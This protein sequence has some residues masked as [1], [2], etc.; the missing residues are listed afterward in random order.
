MKEN[1][2]G[3]ETEVNAYSIENKYF[4]IEKKEL[5]LENDRLLEERMYCDIMCT[6]L[7]YVKDMDLYSELSC[8]FINKCVECE[9]LESELSKQIEKVKNKSFNELL[10]L[11]AKLEEFSISLELSLKHYKE[12]IICNESL[13]NHDASLISDINNKSF[14]INDL[15]SQLQDKSIAVDELKKLLNKLN[16]K[17]KV[18]QCEIQPLDSMSQKLED[19]NVSLKFQ[20]LSL[21]KENEHL[22]LVYKNLYDSIKQTQAQTKLKTNSLQEK[23]NA[24]ISENE[25]LRA[26]LHAKFFKQKNE[27]EVYSQGC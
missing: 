1:F 15:K 27:L 3:M 23:V 17:S 8:M 2:K 9:I 24:K 19:G 21:E 22:K 13:K 5:F 6:I 7:C 26:Q 12:K 11:F 20:V 25:K 18:T 10:K 14:E 16:G 4:Q